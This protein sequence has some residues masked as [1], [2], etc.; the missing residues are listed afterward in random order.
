MLDEYTL[1]QYVYSDIFT[2]ERYKNEIKKYLG[3]KGR[4]VSYEDEVK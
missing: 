4:L 1:Q 2:S 3:C